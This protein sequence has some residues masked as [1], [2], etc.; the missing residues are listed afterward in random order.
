MHS[1]QGSMGFEQSQQLKSV[2][3]E[4]T[5]RSSSHQSMQKNRNRDISAENIY[6][7]EYDL[8][9]ISLQKVHGTTGQPRMQRR[10]KT[11]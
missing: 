4:S 3:V 11:R 6:A 5:N 2:P 7:E 1:T 9:G 10:A 8:G